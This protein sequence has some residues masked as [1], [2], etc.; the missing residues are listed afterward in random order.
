M[1]LLLMMASF[2]GILHT[3]MSMMQ[4]PPPPPRP[5]ASVDLAAV[6]VGPQDIRAVL[7]A[8]TGPSTALSLRSINEQ[9]FWQVYVQGQSKPLY[10]NASQAAIDE[11][12]DFRYAESIAKQHLRTDA[13]RNT[14]YL[15]SFNDEYISIFRIL[16]VWRFDA[17]DGKGTRVY[18]STM[19]G[20]VTRHTDSMKQLEAASFT[21][22]HKWNFISNK[23]LRDA[24]LIMVNLS[25]I[26]LALSGLWL[27]WRT[28][29][30]TRQ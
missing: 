12:A 7:P 21:Y 5:S 3:Y 20:S 9:P 13:V 8:D 11:Q 28:R 22:L 17:D 18:V 27:F 19:T 23:R 26:L 4:D 2:S 29:T 25:L 16:P 1:A 6:A 10:V 15:T 14:E 30:I 24:A